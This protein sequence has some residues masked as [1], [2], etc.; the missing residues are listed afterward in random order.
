MDKI[1]DIKKIEQ[2][3]KIKLGVII[4]IIVAILIV[5]VA[6]YLDYQK[7][8]PEPSPVDEQEVEFVFPKPISPS[9]NPSRAQEIHPDKYWSCA[10]PATVEPITI[11]PPD[12]NWIV[13]KTSQKATISLG[14][15][16]ITNKAKTLLEIPKLWLY[17]LSEKLSNRDDKLYGL[18]KSYV[19]GAKLIVN[20]QEREIKLGGD[21]YMFIELDNYP[22]GDLY[23]YD[24][25][26]G[27]DFE[28]LIELQCKNVENGNCLDNQGQP[29]DYINR[30]DI[31]SQIRIFAI[32]CQEFT[33]DIFI[34]GKF[35]LTGNK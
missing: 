28:F 12:S 4:P 20:E 22:L 3:R 5:G 2:K 7:N 34:Q 21:E 23:P 33:H 29:L 27:L 14:K 17:F 13:D 25:N 6:I 32:G 16:R 10:S 26:I 24:K 19:S 15:Y 30:A 11:K 9:E 18:E 35:D 8:K 31:E 1:E